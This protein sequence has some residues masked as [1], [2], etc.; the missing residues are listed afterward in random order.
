MKTLQLFVLPNET[1]F[2]S[3]QMRPCFW[4]RLWGV[5]LEILWSHSCDWV[6]TSLLFALLW[7]CNF[8][9]LLILLVL[10]FHSFALYWSCDLVVLFSRSCVP[11]LLWYCGLPLGSCSHGLVWTHS[12]GIMVSSWGLVVLFSWSCMDSLLWYYGLSSGVF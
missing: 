4:S 7:S 12:C 10:C 8:L 11:S 5:A 1:N 2:P 3:Y 9:H 6:I